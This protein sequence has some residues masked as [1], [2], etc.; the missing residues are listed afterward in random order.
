MAYSPMRSFI[1]KIS[2]LFNKK[3]KKHFFGLIALMI[4]AAILEMIGLTLLVPVIDVVSNP[5][6][7]STNPYYQTIANFIDATDAAQFIIRFS[8]IVIFY[9]LMKNAYLTFVNLRQANFIKATEIKVT[10][11]LLHSYLLKPYIEVAHKNSADMIRNINQ[12]VGYLFVMVINTLLIVASE[13]F[14]V[15]A[16]LGL[17]MYVSF[18]ATLLAFS[19]LASAVMIFIFGIRK[20]ISRLGSQRQNARGR[21]IEWATQA[22]YSLK[23]LLVAQKEEYFLKNF[24]KNSELTKK[25]EVFD[26]ALS[27]IP[28]LFIETFAIITLLSVMLY[29]FTQGSDF[30]AILSV[31]ALVLLRLMPTMNRIVICLSRARF[32]WPSLNIVVNELEKTTALEYA[33]IET[34]K[35]SFHHDLD[36]KNM[37]FQYPQGDKAVLNNVNFTVKK[38]EIVSIVGASGSGKTTFMDIL[39]G[40]LTP[41]SG[42]IILDG[43]DI[44]NRTSDFRTMVSYLPQS[45]YLLNATIMENIAFGVDLDKIDQNKVTDI[46]GK[47]GLSDMIADLPL[48]LNTP[49]GD[50]SAKISGG[51][52][53]RVGIARALYHDKEIL[54]L[55]EAT[56]G[57]DPETESRICDTLKSL[58]P[59]TT[60]ISISHQEALINIADKI[61]AMDGGILNTRS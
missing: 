49:I 31:F 27:R 55:D 11:Q 21:M 4:V 48:G 36:V 24:Q 52:R 54:F 44:S 37:S 51:Q 39:L 6:K 22:L 61:Y 47:V 7:L 32:Y 35:L 2:I 19:I 42:A 43:Q 26:I 8:I 18:G 53:Q 45:V 9:I 1:H 17:M 25:A 12:E 33:K 57:L 30:I 16:L 28:Q 5:D 56:A 59:N 58:T 34:K 38:G 40:L 29:T 15:T 3:E 14:V 13:L 41:Q 23:E 10:N 20:I 60:I 46:I 50:I